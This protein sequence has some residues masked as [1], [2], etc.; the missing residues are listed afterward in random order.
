MRLDRDPDDDVAGEIGPLGDR[1]LGGRPGDLPLGLGAWF[2]ADI[3]PGQAEVVELLGV[4]LSE[5]VGVE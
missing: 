3:R 2:E 5:L 1:E 4:D